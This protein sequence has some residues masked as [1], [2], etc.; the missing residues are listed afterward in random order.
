VVVALSTARELGLAAVAGAFILFALV[1][2][3]VLPAR[4]HNFPGRRLPLFLAAT[5]VF[6]VAMMAAV[7]VL[8]RE[9][10]EEG[11]HAAEPAA[12][13]T[14]TQAEPGP[15]EGDPE[16]GKGVF[17]SAA[18]GSC[19]TLEAAGSSGTIGPNLDDSAPGYEAIVEQVTNG[20]GGMP[21]FGDQLSDDQIQ[22]VAAFVFASTH[23]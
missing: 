16:A 2:A 11:G 22:D 4:D 10:E 1:A 7:L 3:F 19:H 13:E 9:T 18:C 23:Y 20:G 21:A 17:A 5:V 6:F 12:T 15:V 8:A 14:Q